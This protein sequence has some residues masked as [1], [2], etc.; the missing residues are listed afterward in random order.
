MEKNITELANEL[1]LLSDKIAD[2]QIEA[3]G[4]G[5]A[6]ASM[7]DTISSLELTI[8]GRIAAETDDTGKKKYS[9]AESRE[10]A[11]IELIK[12]DLEINSLK[13]K[14]DLLQN[15]F[16]LKKIEIERLRD[17][18]RNIRSVLAIFTHE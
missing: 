16:S 1:L 8:K 9:N 4:L 7:A 15:D 18:Q 6:T 17:R 11:F 12:H 2:L 5:K 10:V 14:S 13:T 3:L